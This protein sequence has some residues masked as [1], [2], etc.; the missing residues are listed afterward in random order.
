MADA[1]RL[2]EELRQEQDHAGQM[3]KLRRGLETQVKELQTRLD[4]AEATA[5]HGGKKALLSLE[6]RVRELQADLE[7]EQGKHVETQKQ[8]RKHERRAQE[9]ALQVEEDRRAQ[10]RMHDM[11]D[12]M[13]QKMKSYKKQVEEA[14][15]IAAINLTKYRKIQHDLEESESRADS[16][17]S[18]VGHMRAKH[19]SSLSVSDLSTPIGGGV[20]MKTV[21]TRSNI[22]VDRKILD[23]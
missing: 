4:E 14:E 16:A 15:E 3:D 19:R 23:S 21:T 18:M 5:L 2:A 1:A 9:L 8:V 17:E 7:G 13:Q 22:S 6:Q 10:D 20:T 11:I 12:K